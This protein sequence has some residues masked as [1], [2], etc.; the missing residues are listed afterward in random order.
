MIV[1]SSLEQFVKIT[2]TPERFGAAGDARFRHRLTDFRQAGS[3]RNDD[4]PSLP[5]SSVASVD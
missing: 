1:G 4:A 5:W 2:A 3:A